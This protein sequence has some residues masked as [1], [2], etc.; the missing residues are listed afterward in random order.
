MYPIDDNVLE[1]YPEHRQAR[2]W[3]I[4]QHNSRPDLKI[5]DDMINQ[6]NDF[7]ILW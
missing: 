3:M 1:L 7:L 2:S 5:S 4:S 6:P